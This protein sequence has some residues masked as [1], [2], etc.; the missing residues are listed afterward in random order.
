M[1]K[2]RRLPGLDKLYDRNLH[3]IWV[4]ALRSGKYEQ[5]NGL[6][7]YESSDAGPNGAYCCLG[8]LC[9]LLSPE[10]WETGESRRDTEQV[11]QWRDPVGGEDPDPAYPPSSEGDVPVQ[12]CIR[13]GLSHQDMNALIR[14]NDKDE[15]TFA[16]IA[17]YIETNL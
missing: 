7:H 4:A 13:I 8:V 2:T 5:G 15:R 17:D 11:F 3:A 16:Q 1:S 12:T 9:D 14:M 10:G 6:L